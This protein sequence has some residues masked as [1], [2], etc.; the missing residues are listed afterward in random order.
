MSL[1]RRFL[2]PFALLVALS[3]TPARATQSVPVGPGTLHSRL[4]QP[5]GPWVIHLLTVD[6]SDQY[7]GVESL[8]GGGAQMGR[9]AVRAM[10]DN[11]GDASRKPIAAI[12]ADYFARAGK[13]YTTLP[14]GLHVENGELVTLPDL[15]RSVFYL[16]KDGRVGIERFRPSAWLSGP[17]N[18]LYPLSAVNRPPE[19]AELALF[20]PRFG[21]ATRAEV[22]TTQFVLADLSGPFVPNGQVTGRIARRAVTESVPIPP[23]GAVLAANGVAA[24]ALRNLQE[25][26]SV[27]L[28]FG[29]QPTGEGIAQAVGGGPRLVRDGAVSIEYKLER[30]HDAFAANRHPRT[31]IGLTGKQLFLVTVDGRQPG[32]SAGMT[33]REFAT[34]FVNLGCT[35]AMNLDGGGSTTM[36][37]RGQVVNSPSDGRERKVANALAL[38]SLAPA[39]PPGAPPRPPVRITLEPDEASVLAA[40]QLTLKA[41]GLDEY[42]EPTPVAPTAVQWEASPGLGTIGADG[43]FTGGP[44]SAPTSGLVTARCGSMFASSIVSVVPGPARLA[45][46]PARLTLAPGG[47]QQFLLRAYDDDDNLLQVPPDRVTWSCTPAGAM[48]D[49]RGLLRAPKGECRFTITASVRGISTQAQVLVGTITRMLA[50]FEQP[51]EVSFC[52]SPTG[53][54]GSVSVVADPLKPTNHCLRLSYDFSKAGE[55]RTA[56]AVLNLTLPETRTLT[57]NVLGDGQG[58]WLRARLRDSVGRVFPVDLANRVDWSRKWKQVTGWLPEE[59]V[60]PVTLESIY[61]SEYHPDRKPVGEILLDDIGVAAL[62]QE[63]AGAASDPAVE[64]T[65]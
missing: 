40:E 6:L 36:V 28:R 15:Y 60:F 30:F 38:F 4:Y 25:G 13:N 53:V 57:L 51:T 49:A 3:A 19:T 1:L 9:S 63:D 50:D 23:N 8:L 22:V 5:D 12:N 47:A 18:L 61:V 52:A 2:V 16:T 65:P 55:T 7:L 26:D 33:L 14:L 46:L 42:S 56:R 17:G 48:L 21:K 64:A 32:Y 59:A 54:S 44:V 11:G 43:V 24:Y 45:L 37:I 39:L 10:L 20:T 41:Q 31:G 27:C 34:L 62:P 58:A 29:L 35:D